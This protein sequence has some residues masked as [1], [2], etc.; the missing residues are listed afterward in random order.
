MVQKIM[1]NDGF[2]FVCQYGILSCIDSVSWFSNQ[3]FDEL[4]VRAVYW[5]VREQ[6]IT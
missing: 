1:V 3:D 2:K 4:I 6:V 5:S